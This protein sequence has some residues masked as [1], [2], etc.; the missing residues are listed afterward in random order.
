MAAHYRAEWNARLKKAADTSLAGK[1]ILCAYNALVDCQVFLTQEQLQQVFYKTKSISSTEPPRV[2]D[3]K[4]FAQAL[5]RSFSTGKASHVPLEP[6]FAAWLATRFPQHAKRLGGQAGIVA[7]QMARLG[8]TAVLYSPKRAAEVLELTHPKTL[9]PLARKDGLALVA[10]RKAARKGDAAKK[11]WIFEFMRGQA[12]NAAGRKI[13]AP[14][15]NRLILST[16]FEGA[17]EFEPALKPFLPD[18][19]KRLHCAMLAGHH[20]LG[21]K[22]FAHYVAEEGKAVKALKKSNPK[23]RIHFEYVPFEHKQIERAVMAHV[24]ENVDSLGLNEVEII[25]LCEKLGL[26]KEASAVRKRDDAFNLYAGAAALLEKLRMQR[27]HVHAPGFHVL[28]LRKPYPA[29][30]ERVRNAVLFSSVA[31]TSKTLLGREIT[32]G[33][34]RQSLSTPLAANGFAELKRFAEKTGLKNSFLR[35]GWADFG[36]HYALV[37]PGQSAKARKGTVGLGDVVSSCSFLA[38]A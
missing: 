5:L 36:D 27:V 12:V 37:I 21:R 22:G 8:A 16:P 34:L 38:E 9:F 29:P 18:L 25:E 11:N 2:N 17:L 14:R 23:L 35:E 32:A 10:A 28:A 26:Q 15:S 13:V 3:E 30:L 20:Y 6:S 4:T 24:A 31:A 1:G 33:E 7:S 19:G